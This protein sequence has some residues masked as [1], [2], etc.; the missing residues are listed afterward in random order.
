MLFRLPMLAC[1]KIMLP[2]GEKARCVQSE[3]WCVLQADCHFLFA[4]MSFVM[5]IRICFVWTVHSKSSK[6]WRWRDKALNTASK[7]L[8]KKVLSFLC[9]VLRPICFWDVRQ[10]SLMTFTKSHLFFMSCFC[11]YLMKRCRN[12]P[13]ETVVTTLFL[14]S[15]CYMFSKGL[16]Y[17]S[18]LGQCPIFSILKKNICIMRLSPNARRHTLGVNI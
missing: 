11:F 8:Y 9:H 10:C 17:T 14:F 3:A 15:I 5:Q 1:Y 16:E 4:R 18:F 12:M 13:S 2:V 7:F 6:C